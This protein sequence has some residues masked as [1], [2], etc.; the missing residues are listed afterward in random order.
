[1][2]NIEIEKPFM[3]RGRKAYA[4]VRDRGRETFFA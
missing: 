4:M 3:E 2:E 1:V